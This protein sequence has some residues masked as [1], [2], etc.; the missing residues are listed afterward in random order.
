MNDDTCPLCQADLT[1]EPI[2]KDKQEMY[3]HT[4]FSRRI[5]IYNLDEDRTVRYKCPDCD[6]EWER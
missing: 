3:G 4:H 6:G 1:G 2:P 5:G